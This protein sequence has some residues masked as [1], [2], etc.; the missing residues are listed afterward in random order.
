MPTTAAEAVLPREMAADELLQVPPL[1]PFDKVAE[2]PMHSA[3][4]PDMGGGSG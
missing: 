3:E 1:V 4:V 2:E